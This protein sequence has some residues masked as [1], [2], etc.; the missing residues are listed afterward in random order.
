M[1]AILKC[2]ATTHD[3]L[4][5]LPIEDGQLIFVSDQRTIYLD[6]HGLRLS[7]DVIRTVKTNFDRE[8]LV[9]PIEGFYYVEETSS[10]WRYKS[11]E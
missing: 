5:S 2:Y 1:S 3:K 9:A 8:H 7:Y 4:Q 11:S 6:N 10:M